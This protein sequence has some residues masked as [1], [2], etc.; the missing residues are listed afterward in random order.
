VAKAKETYKTGKF[1]GFGFVTSKT[2]PYVLIDLDHVIDGT[3][4]TADWAQE[5][6][7]AAKREGGYIERSPSGTGYHIIGRGRQLENGSKKNDAEIYTSGRFFTITG[8]VVSSPDGA[9]GELGDT[10]ALVRARIN[11][12]PPKSAINTHAGNGARS[13]AHDTQMDD[14]L[15]DQA[16]NAKDGAK[17]RRLFDEGNSSGY[18]SASEADAALAWML[19]FW[20][21]K[22]AA[23]IERLMLRSALHR[24]KWNSHP[25]YLGTTIANAIAKCKETYG[26]REEELWGKPTDFLHEIAAPAL[27]AADVPAVIGDYAVNWAHAGGFDATGVIASC[28]AA[29]AAAL[30]DNVQ[31]TVQSSTNWRESARLWVAI[32]APP[33]YAKSPMIRAA[34]GPLQEI[35]KEEVEQYAEIYAAWQEAK[36]NA[37]GGD[38]DRPPL[39]ATFTNDATIEKLSEVLAD[40]PG[41]VLYLAE[42]LDSWLGSHDA[43]R[44]NGGSRDRGEWLQLFDGGPHQIDRVKRGSFFVPNWGVSLLSATTPVALKRLVGKLPNDGLLQRI[45]PFQIKPPSAPDAA[46]EFAA[47]NASYRGAIRS[48]KKWG[49]CVVELDAAARAALEMELNRYRELAPACAVISDGLAGH[50]AKYGSI[51]ARITLTFHALACAASDPIHFPSA[52]SV[53]AKTVELAARFTRKCFVHARALYDALSGGDTALQLARSVGAALVAAKAQDVERRYLVQRLKAFRDVDDER[54]QEAMQLLTDF[55]WLRPEKGVYH[56]GYPTRWSINPA[57]HTQ[58]KQYGEALLQRRAVVKAAI[59]AAHADKN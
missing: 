48:I 41:G 28:V 31:L 5:I 8:D 21:E 22:D 47:A 40:N 32:I 57:V 26:G 16:R 39:P 51:L 55:A 49:A 12:V 45:L 20:A 54:Q 36:K 10:T 46:V 29:A 18:P 11:S 42:E 52:V 3:G 38:D 4:V 27:E 14:A 43:Y 25:T 24:D 33:G 23:T 30:S 15:I 35:H 2:D 19:C 58:F 53:S 44:S 17:F 34:V 6:V 59:L 9:L 1:D 37:D 13:A 50:V 7:S 56:K